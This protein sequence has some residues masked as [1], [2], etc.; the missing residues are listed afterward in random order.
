MFKKLL[1]WLKALLAAK[2]VAPVEPP[3]VPVVLDEID[4][5]TITW[6]EPRSPAAWPITA[7]IT[8]AAAHADG[9]SATYTGAEAWRVRDD[10]GSKPSVGNWCLIAK[11]NGAWCGAAIE[12]LAKGATRCTGKRFDGTDAI[13][14]ALG[15]WRPTPGET[16]GVMI[17]AV[18]RGAPYTVQERS[19]ITLVKWPG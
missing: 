5:A 1:A 18:I 10:G 14:G 12:W 6:G 3:A 16:V 11:V 15:N 8:S 9:L 19:Q 7:N 13:H 17:C 4:M 2:P